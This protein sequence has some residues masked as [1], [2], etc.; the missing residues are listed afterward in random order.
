MENMED[1]QHAAEGPVLAGL[2]IAGAGAARAGVA[3]ARGLGLA[4]LL[5]AA[6]S[7]VAAATLARIRRLAEA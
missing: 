5:D 6:S 7:L 2:L 3:D 1:R 4:F